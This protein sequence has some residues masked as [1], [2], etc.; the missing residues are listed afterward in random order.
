MFCHWG[1]CDCVCLQFIVLLFSFLIYLYIYIYFLCFLTSIILQLEIRV[2]RFY[3]QKE[4]VSEFS[5]G[6]KTKGQSKLLSQVALQGLI[7]I[8]ENL[9]PDKTKNAKFILIS[10]KSKL[11]LAKTYLCISVI[12]WPAIDKKMHF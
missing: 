7:D 12:C 11:Y 10:I 3:L 1:H 2:E 8:I 6:D 9:I 4:N 5:A